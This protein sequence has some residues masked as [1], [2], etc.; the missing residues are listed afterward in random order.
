M[1]WCCSDE[2]YQK[3]LKEI[4]DNFYIILPKLFD[5]KI[6]F[7]DAKMETLLTIINDEKYKKYLKFK[8]NLDDE[9]DLMDFLNKS[10]L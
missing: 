9:K 5:Q 10:F 4:E 2:D 8:Y 1:W 3:N 6:T 7:R